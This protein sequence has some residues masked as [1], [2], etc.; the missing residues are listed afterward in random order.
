[1][2]RAQAVDV[3]RVATLR[4]WSLRLRVAA[5]ALTHLATVVLRDCA[6]AGLVGP[7]GDAL[8]AMGADVAGQVTE[9]AQEAIA[10]ADELDHE[11]VVLLTASQGPPRASSPDGGSPGG[12][13]RR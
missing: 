4:A 2:R 5:T 7:A 10:A 11:A 13:D 1:V 3:A 8:Q 9:A 12:G 6:D